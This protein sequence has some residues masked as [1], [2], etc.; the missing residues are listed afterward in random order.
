M[1]VSVISITQEPIDTIYRA[2][3]QCYYPGRID[4]D[5]FTEKLKNTS[6]LDKMQFIKAVVKK[7]HMSGLEHVSF[8]F[9]VSGISRAISHQLVRHRI[10]SYSQQSQRHVDPHNNEFHIP[11]SIRNNKKALAVYEKALATMISAY[12]ALREE[13]IPMEDA[14]YILPN[15]T[16]TNIVVTF[17]MHSFINFCNERCCMKAQLEIRQLAAQMLKALSQTNADFGLLTPLCGPKCTATFGGRG[18]CPEQDTKCSMY[19][20]VKDES[21]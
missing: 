19:K 21:N 8:C 4:D 20:A 17:N 11:A 16:T 13:N 10:A 6:K 1:E 2:Y 14:R 9:A 15:A 3:R 18:Y 5:A 12:D 7:G